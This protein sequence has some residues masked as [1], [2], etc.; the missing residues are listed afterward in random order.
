M[1]IKIILTILLIIG[2]FWTMIHIGEKNQ[3]AKHELYDL[4]EKYKNNYD[5]IYLSDLQVF[6][7]EQPIALYNSYANWV[8][9]FGRPK[10]SSGNTINFSKI[11]SMPLIV[12]KQDSGYVL[13]LIYLFDNANFKVKFPKENI[14]IEA[15]QDYYDYAQKFPK[16]YIHSKQPYLG[17]RMDSHMR[18]ITLYNR[19]TASQILAI[20]IMFMKQQTMQLIFLD[21]SRMKFLS[22]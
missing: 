4:K 6:Y 15:Y 8:K 9:L 5:S 16:S 17:R 18:S 22:N 1:K 20:S 2:F 7:K 19:D 13:S 14:W 21:N 3:K 10:D 12:D 11:N